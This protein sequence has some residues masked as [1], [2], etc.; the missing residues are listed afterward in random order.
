MLSRPLALVALLLVLGGCSHFDKDFEIEKAT[1]R[2]GGITG[3]WT[4][5][6]Q[7][8]ANGHHGGL[9]AIIAVTAPNVYS[10]HYHATYGDVF[11]FEYTMNMNTK[12]ENG[13]TTFQG[14]ADL[15]WLAGGVYKFDGHA[16]PTEFFSS[17]SAEKDHGT[18]TMK[19]P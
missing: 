12:T 10:I 14:E 11:T 13:Q 19:R 1:A 7:S 8:E 2:P 5:T 18:Y 6:W 15:G 4:G 16:T 3:A 17:Y 9:R